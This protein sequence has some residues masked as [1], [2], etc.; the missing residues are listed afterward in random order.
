M[1]NFEANYQRL[2]GN[3][4]ILRV[5]KVDSLTVKVGPDFTAMRNPVIKKADIR[6][7]TPAVV[8]GDK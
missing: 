3:K 2:F 7:G 1:S 4:P 5:Q 6:E 8:G